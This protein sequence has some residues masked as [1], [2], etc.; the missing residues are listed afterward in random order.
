MTIGILERRNW[1]DG[2]VTGRNCMLDIL[3]SDVKFLDDTSEVPEA[4]LFIFV[5]I[6]CETLRYICIYVSIVFAKLAS[7]FRVTTCYCISLPIP[8]CDTWRF[9]LPRIYWE[10]DRQIRFY[11]P[12]TLT[13][14]YILENS[15][16][17]WLRIFSHIDFSDRTT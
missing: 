9:H 12:I 15:Q 1:M 8:P 7:G 10:T 5:D 4:S 3:R 11:S 13:P 16:N 17:A 14:V 6:F 2:S